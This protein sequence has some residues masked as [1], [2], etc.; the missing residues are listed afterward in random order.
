MFFFPPLLPLLL[1]VAILVLA[2]LALLLARRTEPEQYLFPWLLL[3]LALLPHL[4]AA[5]RLDFASMLTFY[6]SSPATMGP[7]ALI[8]A[9]LFRRLLSWNDPLFW[10]LALGL[11]ALWLALIRLLW[12]RRGWVAAY[13]LWLLGLLLPAVLLYGR[14]LPPD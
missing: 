14:L 7:L 10:L 11:A 4:L 5:G 2:L 1:L 3:P 9:Y 12:Q 6:I 13:G 8:F